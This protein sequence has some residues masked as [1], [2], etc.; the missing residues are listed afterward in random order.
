MG[1]QKP[2]LVLLVTKNGTL[3][4]P[5]SFLHGS[6]ESNLKV[7]IIM[8]NASKSQSSMYVSYPCILEYSF[9]NDKAHSYFRMV[10]MQK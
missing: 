4:V 3:H 9:T 5:V 1:I 6:T 7:R 8:P 10:E 2:I